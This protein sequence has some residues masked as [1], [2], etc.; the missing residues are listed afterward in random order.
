MAI[1]YVATTIAGH[2]SACAAATTNSAK[3]KTLED[4]CKYVFE[5]VPDVR[6]LARN[7][8]D[9]RKAHELDLAFRNGSL[10]LVAP[11]G[12]PL[13]LECKNHKSPVGSQ[14]IGW[15]STKLKSRGASAGILVSLSGITGI[16]KAGSGEQ[17]IL[18]SLGTD[19]VRIV[20]LTVA[21][22]QTLTTTDDLVDRL[23]DKYEA[24]VLH[25]R[26]R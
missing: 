25:R 21:D 5:Q 18:D 23:L 22:L 14:H 11:F 1:P 19:G 4:F 10:A 17:Q 13:I 8:L 24:L 2:V 6:F 12:S 16:G 26:V 3:G 9:D 15:F 7:I 20:V